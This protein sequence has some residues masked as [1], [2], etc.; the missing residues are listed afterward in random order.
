M[1]PDNTDK[2]GQRRI[3][4]R[5]AR[6]KKGGPNPVIY[7]FKQA[8]KYTPK[9]R[10]SLLG[11]WVAFI[12]AG[13]LNLYVSPMA[14]AKISDVIQQEGVNPQNLSWL[15]TLLAIMLLSTI[16]FWV[17]HGPARVKERVLAFNMRTQFRAFFLEG[18]FNLPL[19]WHADHH[20]GDTIDKIDKGT[21]ALFD[22]A[23]DSFEIIYTFVKLVGSFAILL[24]FFPIA[25]IG[26]LIMLLFTCWVTTRFDKLLMRQYTELN[27]AEN[28]VTQSTFDSLS[29]ITTVIILR[30]EKEVFESIM[31]RV[32][33][34]EKLF[35]QN[36]TLNELKWFVTSLCCTLTVTAV[37]GMYFHH[38]AY[39]GAAVMMG[40]VYLLYRYLGNISE[41][42]SRFASIYGEV[43]KGS[44]R[45]QNAAQLS[46]D[47]TKQTFANHV[48][49]KEWKNLSVDG[50]DFSYT[51]GDVGA[52]QLED[53]KLE[54]GHGERI[55]FVGKSGCGKS[56]LLTLI[57]GLHKPSRLTLSV[58]G[59]LVT[60]GF[61][62]IARAISLVPQTPE[63]FNGTIR[64]NLTL[65][66]EYSEEDIA[67]AMRMADFDSV[68]SLLPK[69]LESS[70]NEKGVNLSGGQQQR[71]ALARGL[72][73]SEN[74]SIVLLD[75]PTS[76]LDTST[77][78]RVYTNIFREFGGKTIISS[79]HRLHLLGQF[80]RIYVFDTGRIIASGTLSELLGN[81]PQF[82]TLWQQ[83]Q[84]CSQQEESEQ[85]D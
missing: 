21:R 69:G 14:W 52:K 84:A 12:I 73:A 72:L 51:Q 20:S 63:I 65:G 61:D 77:E 10:K 26:V 4:S 59:E 35:R 19:A 32:R 68:V 49:P 60:E 36:C 24:Y 33:G 39:N 23:E 66:A 40:E 46:G 62:G 75:E 27:A 48:L 53:I 54:I 43:M 2:D 45:L 31:K 38:R 34:P 67:W 44:A 5:G 80:D 71:L 76:S 25:S 28:K 9:D 15:Y 74:K 1:K 16:G 81:C 79:I 13:V 83:Y 47:F 8:W 22:F 37:L 78:N 56:T 55:A 41:V 70:V 58:D 7:L 30:V 85:V 42:F 3:K 17:I 18:A 64:E 11:I 6:K 57:R 50:L 82:Q 29:N